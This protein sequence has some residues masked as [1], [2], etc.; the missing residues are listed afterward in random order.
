MMI[1]VDAMG[2]DNAPVSTVEGCLLALE[3]RQDLF[4]T[5]IGDTEKI[6]KVLEGKKYDKDRIIIRHTTEEISNN[7]VPTK[8]I[9]KKKDSSM[10]VG[11]NMLKEGQGDVFISAGSSGALLIGS[12]CITKRLPG[13]DR[14]ALGS[15]YPTK[16]GLAL[17]MDSGLNLVCRPD[18]YLQF[19]KMGAAYLKAAFGIEKPAVGL[20]N[21]GTEEQKGN[22]TLRE[23]N[24]LLRASNLN[25]KGN[26]ESRDIFDGDI[27]VVVTDGFTGNV[28]LKMMEGAST[29][30]LGKMKK[31]FTRDLKSQFG[32]FFLRKSVKVLK[33]ELD[34]DVYGGAPILGV[35][36]LV[37]KS[38]GS[39]T[40]RTIKYVVLKAAT[41]IDSNFLE[42]LKHTLST[43]E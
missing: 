28:I 29:F 5:L 15:I 22:S 13:V 37:I 20:I 19:A 21:V 25:Y 3:E 6:N 7:D 1:L 41:L 16:T 40:A 43:Q 4:I 26:I 23:A 33:Q 8:A 17:L 2:G 12:V 35:D 42:D 30:L 27:D 10:V 32:A 38:H 14:P 11:F 18:Y 34:A 31:S 9:S 39:S 24:D 36:G